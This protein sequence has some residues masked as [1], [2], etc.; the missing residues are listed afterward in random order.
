MRAAHLLGPDWTAVRWYRSR[1]E[2]DRAYE[3]MVHEQP[4][5]RLGD[6]PSLVV[7]TLDEEKA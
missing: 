4:Y 2:R 1:E 3:A 6:I 7:E 5:A